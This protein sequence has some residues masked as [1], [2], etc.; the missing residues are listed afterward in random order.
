MNKYFILSMKIGFKN[1][2]TIKEGSPVT[3]DFRTDRV[4]VFVNNRGIVTQ[5]PTI[6]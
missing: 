4:R 5:V 1:V 2:M 3:M 6:A